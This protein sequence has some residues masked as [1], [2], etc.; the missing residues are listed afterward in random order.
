MATRKQSSNSAQPKPQPP[1]IEAEVVAESHLDEYSELVTQINE[2]RHTLEKSQRKEN[3]LQETVDYLQEQLDDQKALIQK[4]QTS[5][6]KT[7]Q[8]HTELEQAQKMALKLAEANQE[9]IAE[10]HELKQSQSLAEHHSS[11]QN[12]QQNALQLAELPKPDLRSQQE[13]LRQR[14]AARLSHPVFPNRPD[15]SSEPDVGWVD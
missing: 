6:E 4:L 12:G 1:V 13:V 14:Q 15:Q 7:N 9:L 11:E 8:I 10:N 2:L 5:I 3:T